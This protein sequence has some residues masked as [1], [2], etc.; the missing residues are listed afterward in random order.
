MILKVLV[1]LLLFSGC[2]IFE[3]KSNS[4]EQKIE[5]LISKYGLSKEHFKKMEPSQAVM[6][7][8]ALV[9]KHCRN[10]VPHEPNSKNLFENC[11]T[12]CDGFSYVLE[13]LLTYQGLHARHVS[14]FNILNQGNHSLI[15][16]EVDGKFALLDPTFGAVFLNNSRLMS[17]SEVLSLQEKDLQG[18][19]H[20]VKDRNFKSTNVKEIYH[21]GFEASYMSLRSYLS[22][23]AFHVQ[24]GRFVNLKL[25]LDLADK[26]I[27][28]WKLPP[29]LNF[30]QKNLAYLNKTNETLNNSVEGDEVSYNFSFMGGKKMIFRNVIKLENM[31]KFKKYAIHL[32]GDALKEGAVSL[33]IIDGKASFMNDFIKSEKPGSFN[34][35]FNFT[36]I[37]KDLIVLIEPNY[38]SGFEGRLW[39]ITVE[40]L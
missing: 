4:T 6:L 17:L 33:S 21:N 37:S 26:K 10:E 23:E 12:S 1:V 25:K 30:E 11:R 22:Y 28:E 9:Y 40:K 14:L 31:E 5:T 19:V 36:P 39:N 7:S 38:Y 8:N 3:S 24:D 2:K 29:N 13:K 27:L 20:Q 16:V 34:A 32:E 35:S 15:E 18:M